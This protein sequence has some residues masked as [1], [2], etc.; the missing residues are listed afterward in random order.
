MLAEVP[1]DPDLPQVAPRPPARAAHAFPTRPAGPLSG[2]LLA[3]AAVHG[4]GDCACGARR[5]AACPRVT[6]PGPVVVTSGPA[7]TR[8]LCHPP[9]APMHVGGRCRTHYDRSLEALLRCLWLDGLLMCGRAPAFTPAPRAQAR[10]WTSGWD[11]FCPSENL[12][13]HLYVTKEHGVSRPK[14]WDEVAGY[15]ESQARPPGRRARA[16]PRGRAAPRRLCCAPEA[17]RGSCLSPCTSHTLPYHRAADA[18]GGQGQVPAGPGPAAGGHPDPRAMRP[19][20]R[21]H[22]GRVL[23]VGRHRPRQPK[24]DG[25]GRPL[26]QPR[27]SRAGAACCGGGAGFGGQESLGDPCCNRLAPVQQ[28]VRYTPV[29]QP[30]PCIKSCRPA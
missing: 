14:Y 30:K 10:L 20:R 13:Y 22:A 15:Y 29:H 24:R 12:I 8:N 23:A 28:Q 4:R 1:F 11:M 2:A 9:I 18:L 25:L 17:I 5:R 26:L 16:P 3:R 19:R 27:L 21:A 6:V 7:V